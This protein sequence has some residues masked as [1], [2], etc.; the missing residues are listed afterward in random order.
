VGT[1]VCCL[2]SWT[3][4]LNWNAHETGLSDLLPTINRRRM[5]AARPVVPRTS[6]LTSGGRV[7][8]AARVDRNH[9]CFDGAVWKRAAP[10]G[11]VARTAAS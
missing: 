10:T 9:G 7:D 3:A 5:A 4:E 2:Q 8:E 1:L 6:R 11:V